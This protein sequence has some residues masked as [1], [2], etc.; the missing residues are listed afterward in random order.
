MEDHFS[1]PVTRAID[2]L[3]EKWVLHIVRNLLDGPAGFNELRRDVGGCNPT[4]L[5]ERLEHLV[6]L[7]LVAKTVVS[8]MP[9]RTSYALTESGLALQDVIGAI[10]A[11]ARNALPDEKEEAVA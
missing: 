6:R 9:P 7:G 2:L 8:T 4:T 3:Q 5:A 11:W 10:D 1:C